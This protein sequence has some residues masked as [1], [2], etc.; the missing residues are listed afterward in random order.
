MPTDAIL[1]SLCKTF[2]SAHRYWGD[3]CSP[4]SFGPCFRVMAMVLGNVASAAGVYSVYS[5]LF[6][7]SGAVA[8]GSSRRC[9]TLLFNMPGSQAVCDRRTLEMSIT[10]YLARFQLQQ[11][12]WKYVV[13]PVE[14][15]KP[16]CDLD[17]T[18]N[19]SRLRLLLSNQV[20]QAFASR[21]LPIASWRCALLRPKASS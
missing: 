14:P 9:E 16:R 6:A 7:M 17:R 11:A 4:W 19:A 18:A 20:V 1:T 15:A 21:L 10:S 8:V 2:Q 3:P 5:P 12:S 13:S